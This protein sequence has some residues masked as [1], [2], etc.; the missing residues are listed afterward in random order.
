MTD[1]PLDEDVL[2]DV[3]SATRRREVIRNLGELDPPVDLGALVDSMT[4]LERETREDPPPNLRSSIYNTTK[5]NH[6]PKMDACGIIDLQNHGD[7]ISTGPNYDIAADVLA[8]AM[9]AFE[10]HRANGD[11]AC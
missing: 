5:Q 7:Q 3:L 6:L 4:D 10:R 9:A 2:F 8:A 1:I 11:L